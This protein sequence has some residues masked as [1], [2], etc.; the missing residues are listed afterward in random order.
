MH[1]IGLKIELRTDASVL[2]T[3][4]ETNELIYPL[5]LC[6]EMTQL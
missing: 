3:A 5:G 2:R 1:T 4:A 6:G